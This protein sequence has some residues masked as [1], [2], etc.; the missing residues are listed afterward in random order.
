VIAVDDINGAIVDQRLEPQRRFQ[1][2]GIFTGQQRRGRV[3][4]DRLEVPPAIEAA[5]AEQVFQPI[6]FVFLEGPA[7]AD[8]VG[9]RGAPEAGS[10]HGKRRIVTDGIA[11]GRDQL[12][13]ER[14]ALIGGNAAGGVE[15]AS[16]L[17]AVA[18]EVGGHVH[19]EE[20]EALLFK[21]PEPVLQL[22]DARFQLPKP[23]HRA[24]AAWTHSIKQPIALR[25]QLPEESAGVMRFPQHRR[26]RRVKLWF[27]YHL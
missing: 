22:A 12:A 26:Q 18:D 13:A 3:R 21:L 4:L 27:S 5:G 17:A 23:S 9:N 1:A 6:Q 15:G 8:A 16:I 25:K 20:G 19:L 14:Q 2:E 7:R 11:H 10:I 24:K